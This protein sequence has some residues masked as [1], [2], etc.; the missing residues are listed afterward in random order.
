MLDSSSLDGLLRAMGPYVEHHQG[1]RE[2]FRYTLIFYELLD[3]VF[4]TTC[5]GIGITVGGLYLRKTLECSDSS[6]AT[7]YFYFGG[8]KGMD[9]YVRKLSFQENILVIGGSV[10]PSPY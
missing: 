3:T 10:S 7:V 5:H 6:K 4:S 1:L 9:G 8:T 2:Y